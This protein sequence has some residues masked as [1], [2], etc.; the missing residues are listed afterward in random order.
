MARKH[1]D[2]VKNTQ[3]HPKVSLLRHDQQRDQRPKL[4]AERPRN[5]GLHQ[6]LLERHWNNLLQ[7][8]HKGVGHHSRPAFHRKTCQ[9]QLLRRHCLRHFARI[10][11]ETQ[12]E[13]NF[14]VLT[15]IQQPSASFYPRIPNLAGLHPP[16]PTCLAT[17]Q[18]NDSSIN[19]EPFHSVNESKHHVPIAPTRA[20]D[21]PND[22]NDHHKSE[23]L[24]VPQF[25]VCHTPVQSAHNSEQPA[26]A[27][28][29]N[30]SF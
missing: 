16:T 9:L 12:R 22:H 28:A 2:T 29:S 14:I 8:E 15:P 11:R 30:R 18:Q 17:G 25:L 23:P 20:N 27:L 3:R 6:K 21:G 24:S 5:P 13:G 10:Q 19:P 1:H 26:S 7:S 4:L